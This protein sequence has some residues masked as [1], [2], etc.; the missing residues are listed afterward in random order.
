VRILAYHRVNDAHPGDRL[1]VHPLEFRRQMEHIAEC[2]RPVLPLREAVLRLKGE[3]PPL[4]PGT[5]CLTFDDGYRDNL[6]FAAPVLE[7]L[8]FPAAVFLVTGRMGAEPA[9]DR[10]QGCC[11]CDAALTWDEAADLRRR[12]HA[13]GGHGRRH[14]EL[15]ALEV[16]EA[17]EEI[18]G[19]R[20][21]LRAALGETPTLFCYPRGSENSTVRH[22]V[23]EAGFQVAVTVYPGANG[24]DADPLRLHRTEISGHDDLA[25]FRLKL[26]GAFDGWHRL[27][28]RVRPRGTRRADILPK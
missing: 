9:I 21:D 18:F 20:D 3:G 23:S 24:Q 4:A 16:A 22:A 25:D 12:G 17:R 28:Q 5:L 19:C 13:L 1:S 11:E 2:A 7:Q 6:Q 15:A 10:Y 14:Q 26:D 8:G 27:R